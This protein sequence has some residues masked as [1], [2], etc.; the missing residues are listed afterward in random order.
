MKMD[1][2]RLDFL[3]IS[4]KENTIERQRERIPQPLADWLIRIAARLRYNSITPDDSETEF[5]QTT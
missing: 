3:I 4:A 5:D 1:D 2:A